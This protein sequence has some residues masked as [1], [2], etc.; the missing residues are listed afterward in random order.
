MRNGDNRFTIMIDQSKLDKMALNPITVQAVGAESA[1][2]EFK[3]YLE[4]KVELKLKNGTDDYT[5]VATAPTADLKWKPN[6]CKAIWKK[7]FS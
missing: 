2:L 5:F 4:P 6:C 1:P 3:V 7:K